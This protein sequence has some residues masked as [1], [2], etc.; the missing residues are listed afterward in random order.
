MISKEEK[1]RL[2]HLNNLMG[3]LYDLVDD[4]SESLVDRDKQSAE[5]ALENLI[6]LSTDIKESID[7]EIK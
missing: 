7:H 6:S 3:Q 1:E 5:E 2:S 4:I